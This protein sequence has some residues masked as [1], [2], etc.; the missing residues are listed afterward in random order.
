ML[1]L[2]RFA[3]LLLLIV[4]G[5]AV[6][7]TDVATGISFAPKTK[8]LEIFGVG[9]RKK[10]PIKIYSVACYG[11][12]ALKDT[13]SGISRS[14]NEEGALSALREGTK[15]GNATFLLQ[16]SRKV[17]AAKMASAIADSVSPRHKGSAKDV[18][19]LRDIIFKGVSEKGAIKGTTF[20][21][22]CASSGVSVT[23]DGKAKGSVAS[24][25]LA[26]AFCDVYCD[27]KCVSPPL[28]ASC[29]ENCCAP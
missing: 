22:D 29:L 24:T 10:G 15:S 13:L 21:F 28:R 18:D 20:Q 3:L 9:V 6:A 14:K 4:A 5:S 17:G 25:A 19:D 7:M 8:G 23:V 27:D 11:N 2:A 16:M 1:S 26:G 12:A